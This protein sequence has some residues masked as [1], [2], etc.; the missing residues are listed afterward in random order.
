MPLNL[1]Q[2]LSILWESVPQ[3]NGYIKIVWNWRIRGTES[4]ETDEF[5]SRFDGRK[6]ISSIN[7]KNNPLDSYPERKQHTVFDNYVDSFISRLSK[8]VN[9]DRREKNRNGGNKLI[10]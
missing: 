6:I 8:M 2:Y 9:T 4:H 5:C 7:T 10:L 1:E 3:I